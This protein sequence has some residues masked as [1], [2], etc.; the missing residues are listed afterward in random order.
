MK[1]NM[2]IL[3]YSSNFQG[4]SL[5]LYLPL[6]Q[7]QEEAGRFNE[8]IGV[9]ASMSSSREAGIVCVKVWE[10]IFMFRQS[11]YSALCLKITIL[12]CYSHEIFSICQTVAFMSY[13]KLNFFEPLLQSGT[14]LSDLHVIT[15]LIL[16][17][18]L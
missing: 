15:H 14:I 6:V 3:P 5:L 16:S 10:N 8:Q 1:N 7:T 17:T 18:A 13:K 9:E 2:K 11:Y 4:Q 12:L